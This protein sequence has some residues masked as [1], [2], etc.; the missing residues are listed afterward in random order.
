[1]KKQFAIDTTKIVLAEMLNKSTKPKTEVEMDN[2][3]TD[4]A[5]RLVDLLHLPFVIVNEV[6]VCED[7]AHWF[8][9]KKLDIC[10]RCFGNS[11]FVEQTE[12]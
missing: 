4:Y 8:N 7:C 12:R 11:H 9:G 3:I 1:M 5:G 10:R 2:L 6:A